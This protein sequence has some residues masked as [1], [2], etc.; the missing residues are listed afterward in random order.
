M[1]FPYRNNI[2]SKR[3]KRPRNYNF[4]LFFHILPWKR[5]AFKMK[6]NN[7]CFCF[8]FWLMWKIIFFF[9]NLVGSELYAQCVSNICENHSVAF[10]HNSRLSSCSLLIFNLSFS[11][12]IAIS[13]CCHTVL[14]IKK[15]IS[16]YKWNLLI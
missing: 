8:C 3:T 7:F 9:F 1:A 15:K 12:M 10:Y 2:S 4:V 6:I 11:L 5:K 16:T 13:F 14:N